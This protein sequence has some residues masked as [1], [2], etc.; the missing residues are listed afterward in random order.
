MTSISTGAVSAGMYWNAAARPR[1]SPLDHILSLHDGPTLERARERVDDELAALHLVTC[2]MRRRRNALASISVLPPEI[3]AHIFEFHSLNYPPAP[4]HPAYDF[5]GPDPPTLTQI[6]LGWITITHVC[7]HWRQVAL[8][9]PSL[10]N[11]ISFSLGDNWAKEMLARSKSVPILYT[12]EFR[13]TLWDGLER[14][15]QASALNAAIASDTAVL[16]SH[17]SHVR[18]LKLWGPSGFLSPVVKSLTSPAPLLE[19]LDLKGSRFHEF[20]ISLPSHLFAGQ[21]PRLRHISLDGCR[22]SWTSPVLRDLESLSVVVPYERR[23]EFPEHNLLESVT[24]GH[25][26]SGASAQ[27][28]A[29]WAPTYDQLFRTLGR[30]PA[31][32]TLKLDGCLPPLTEFTSGPVELPV[33]KQLNLSGAVLQ[34][35]QLLGQLQV[36]ASAAL[37]IDCWSYDHTGNEFTALLP[38][39][40]PHL[41][42][43]NGNGTAI[44]TLKLNS[45]SYPV[46]LAVT[47]WNHVLHDT[48]EYH[49][50]AKLHVSFISR[51][52]PRLPHLFLVQKICKAFPLQA[53]RSLIVTLGSQGSDWLP[54]HWT[55]MFWRC[56]NVEYAQA[57][58]VGAISLSRALVNPVNDPE[59]A[60]TLLFPKLATLGLHHASFMSGGPFVANGVF[61][62]QLPLWLRTRKLAKVPIR[63]VEIVGCSVKPEWVDALTD[64]VPDVYWDSDKGDFEPIPDLE[65]I[66]SGMQL[67]DNID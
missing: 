21:A 18:T 43:S 42:S 54:E 15:R 36:P 53:L 8:E 56:T 39:L 12:R 34:C 25:E 2:S 44:R 66:S 60:R 37:F 3:I 9:H 64:V 50:T 61:H 67:W 45:M 26:L 14:G 29:S 17:I 62:E 47:A 33:L 58:D 49:T 28:D 10:W 51:A 30:M 1:M 52:S 63:R 46:A 32:Q 20:L 11:N 5:D 4:E 48:S 31:L 16:T 13:S 24:M 6:Q 27:D 57:S 38:L 35:V 7:H 19:S 55:S 65:S 40:S 23:V 41:A 22:V 59:H